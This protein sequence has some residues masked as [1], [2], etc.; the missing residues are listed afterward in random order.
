MKYYIRY[1]RFLLMEFSFVTNK[2]KLK[3][4]KSI[5]VNE[6]AQIIDDVFYLVNNQI[7]PISY[8]LNLL[9]YISKENRYLPWKYAIKHIK[10]ILDFVEDHSQIYAKF[11]V[12]QKLQ[13]FFSNMTAV[14]NINKNII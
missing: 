8:G 13:F 11:R 1:S 10:T 3:K 2:K 9:E 6:R 14:E 12:I 7:M 4:I 5:G